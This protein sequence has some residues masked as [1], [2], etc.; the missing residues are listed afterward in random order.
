MI[1]F[2][3]EPTGNLDSKSATMVLSYLEKINTEEKRTI[4]LVTHDA[5]AASF[6]RRIVFIA[7]G[8]VRK[9]LIRDSDKKQF[10]KKI[11]DTLSSMNAG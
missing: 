1:I 10:Y 5:Y 4:V 6:C 7:D 2:A 3:D 9:E 8:K 11:L